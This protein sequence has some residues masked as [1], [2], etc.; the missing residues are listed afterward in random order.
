[1]TAIIPSECS[2]EKIVFEHFYRLELKGK[3]KQTQT[4]KYKHINIMNVYNRKKELKQK[5]DIKR[6]EL[7]ILT[8]T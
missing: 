2:H 8:F 6:N 5:D 7:N 3:S 4:P 1:M